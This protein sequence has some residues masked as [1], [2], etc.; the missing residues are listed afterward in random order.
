MMVPL[1]KPLLKIYRERILILAVPEPQG[2]RGATASR[3]RQQV[4]LTECVRPVVLA[5]HA[6]WTLLHPDSVALSPRPAATGRAYFSA[7]PID[8]GGEIPCIMLRWFSGKI[9]FFHATVPVHTRQN[10][11]IASIWQQY[12]WQL[13]KKPECG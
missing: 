10:I 12:C 9:K 8:D 7:V 1:S 3:L 13:N 4:A 11:P 6:R 2:L 5:C